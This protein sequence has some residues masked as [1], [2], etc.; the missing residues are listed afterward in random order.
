MIKSFLRPYLWLLAG[1]IIL[2]QASCTTS[3]YISKASDGDAWKQNR[4]ELESLQ[5]WNLQGKIS[6]RSG[7]DLYTADLYWQQQQHNLNMRLVAPFSQGVTQFTG[8][9]AKGYQVL[10]EQ[11]ELIDVDSPETVTDHAFGVSLPFHELK[12]WIKGLPDKDAFVWKAKFNQQNR[13]AEFQQSGWQIKFLKYKKTGSQWLPAKLFLSR[14]KED[15][16]DN[17]VDVRLIVR[18]WMI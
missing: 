4:A 15:I 7:E 5:Q 10:T 9:D 2:L 8:N 11:G 17:K 3:S 12:S 14:I 13:L 6:I 1:G 18:R 16:S